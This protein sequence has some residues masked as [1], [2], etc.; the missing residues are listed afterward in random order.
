MTLVIIKRGAVEHEAEIIH[1][2]GAMIEVCY[3]YE[4]KEHYGRCARTAL[5][6]HGPRADLWYD[7]DADAVTWTITRDLDNLETWE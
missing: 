4:G 5:T 3:E 2:D 7:L 1:D 6:V